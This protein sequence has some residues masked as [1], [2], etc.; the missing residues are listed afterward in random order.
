MQRQACLRLR[1]ASLRAVLVDT[2]PR[3]QAAARNLAESMGALYLPLPYA[4]A[5][6]LARQVKT[7][8]AAS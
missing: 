3:P 6:G 2:A 8:A 7:A 1:A 5:A 4:D